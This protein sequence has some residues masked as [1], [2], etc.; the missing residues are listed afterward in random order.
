MIKSAIDYTVSEDEFV[1]KLNGNSSGSCP[2][3]RQ[4]FIEWSQ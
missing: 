4:P 2:Y 1:E 3:Y